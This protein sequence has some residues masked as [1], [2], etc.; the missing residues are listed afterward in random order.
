[1]SLDKLPAFIFISMTLCNGSV[2]CTYISQ[3]VN[4]PLQSSFIDF[5]SYND[6]IWL[7]CPLHILQ[8]LFLIQPA[9]FFKIQLKSFCILNFPVL[10]SKIRS[11]FVSLKL[12]S[13]TS[14]IMQCNSSSHVS[15]INLAWA[16]QEKG[17]Q[18]KGLIDSGLFI[19]IFFISTHIYGAF[20]IC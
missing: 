20:S 16:P 19:H 5:I 7:V 18:R 15:L 17:S 4:P 14:V 11:F 9:L 10:P 2:A 1:M 6:S 3:N 13:F 8:H 12:F